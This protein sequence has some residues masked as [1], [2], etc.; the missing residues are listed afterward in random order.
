MFRQSDL[1]PFKILGRKYDIQTKGT[2]TSDKEVSVRTQAFLPSGFMSSESSCLSVCPSFKPEQSSGCSR[3]AS[4]AV[5][6]QQFQRQ[7]LHVCEALQ[8]R[9]MVGTVLIASL[10]ELEAARTCCHLVSAT[11]SL[12]GLVSIP[13]SLTRHSFRVYGMSTTTKSQPGGD[14]AL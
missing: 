1:S 3:S 12:S 2:R 4:Q 13:G 8:D 7:R 6:E 14:R 9:Q 5:I 11:R 10:G